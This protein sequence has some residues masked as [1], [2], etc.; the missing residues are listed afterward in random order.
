MVVLEV[1]TVSETWMVFRVCQPCAR[2]VTP[3]S[4]GFHDYWNG[5]AS[6]S[7]DD[8]S[9][10]RARNIDSQE[11]GACAPQGRCQDHSGARG[12]QELWVRGLTLLSGPLGRREAED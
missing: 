9:H 11:E 3:W 2:P 10:K 12:D 5:E 8:C 4:M 6:G 7:A 1:H